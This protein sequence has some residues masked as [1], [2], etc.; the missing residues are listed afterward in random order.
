MSD[1]YAKWGD[2]RARGRAADPRTPADQ[3]AGKELARDRHEAACGGS[4]AEGS[5]DV[6]CCA[7]RS[8]GRATRLQ[9]LTEDDG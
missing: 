3:A 6:A 8:E 4:P 2:V 5:R 7:G 1:G 9:V